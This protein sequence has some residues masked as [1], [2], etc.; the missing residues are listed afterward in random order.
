MPDK[1]LKGRIEEHYRSLGRIKVEVPEWEVTLYADPINLEQKSRM[2]AWNTTPGEKRLVS[3]AKTVIML[4]QN[5]DG[6]KVFSD[7]DLDMLA[8][9]S[10]PDVVSRVSN[11]LSRVPEVEDLKND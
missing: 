6:S 1:S 10:D 11:E 8:H 5:E 9:R 7:S 2:Y 3:F 4:A